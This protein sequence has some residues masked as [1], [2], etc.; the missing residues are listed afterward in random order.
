MALRAALLQSELHGGVL[1]LVALG[2]RLFAGLGELVGALLQSD[3]LQDFELSVLALELAAA[4]LQRARHRVERR[5]RAG[6]SRRHRGQ[7]P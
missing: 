5:R 4:L 7:G 3:R 2:A 6:R 1:E